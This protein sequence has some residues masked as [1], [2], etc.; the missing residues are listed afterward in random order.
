MQIP[1]ERVAW[2]PTFRKDREETVKW[3]RH[4]ASPKK[5]DFPHPQPKSL[6]WKL[7]LTAISQLHKP[8]EKATVHW[9]PSS[10]L[11]NPWYDTTSRAVGIL[12]E[13][14]AGPASPREEWE[15]IPHLPT[16]ITTVLGPTQGKARSLHYRRGQPWDRRDICQSVA[17]L[18]WAL[19][20]LSRAHRSMKGK[21]DMG[22]NPFCSRFP[23]IVFRARISA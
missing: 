22:Q 18:R 12:D 20:F 14:V 23:R 2:L 16:P 10:H 11:W 19:V 15:P 5:N 9:A 4:T 7:C 3:G 17:T 6:W 13:L 21:G 8:L 1:R